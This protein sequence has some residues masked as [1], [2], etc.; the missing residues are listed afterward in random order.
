MA[1]VLSDR[2]DMRQVVARLERL[3]LC[4]WHRNMRLII[5]TAWFFD[6]FDSLAIAFVLPALIGLWKLTPGQIGAL[7][8]VGFAGQAVGSIGAGW[9]AERWGRLKTMMAMLLVFALGSLACAFTTS[10]DAMWWVRFVQGIGLGGEVPLM[11]AYV[12]E[13]AKSA[14]RGQ[15]SLSI[16]VLFAISLAVVAFV[17]SWVVPHLGWQWM[18]IIGAVPAFLTIPL[19]M[20]LPESP[21]WLASQSRMDDADA[22]LA[23]IERIA[24]SEGKTLPPLPQNLPPGNEARPHFAE[25]FKGIYLKRTLS[26]WGIWI[27]TYIITYGLTAWAPSLYRTVYHL[28]VGRANFYGFVLNAVALIGALSAIMLIDRLGRRRMFI[29]GLTVGALP[30]LAFAVIGRPSA[31]QVLTLTCMSFP[32]ISLLALSLAT[33]TA[34]N[35]PTHLRALGGGV[36][37]AWQ[38]LA[39]MAGPLLVGWMLPI[40]GLNAIFVVFGLFAA[41][42][43]VI[44][45]LFSIE[46]R[47]EVLE[48][49][50]PN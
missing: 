28:D 48:R 31:V 38:R 17:G 8:S 1:S 33:Y 14:R 41:A 47:G 3:P 40:W 34:E 49:L 10:Y 23:R 22:S 35:Y 12:N 11:A 4:S 37:G 6:A 15:F 45:V 27:F 26:V 36:A 44:T 18:F 2:V 19:W 30:L 13:F 25:L 24:V 9:V 29:L 5:S 21:R 20:M 43:T 32:F 7:I 50:N 46:T 39:S 42:G 16:Q